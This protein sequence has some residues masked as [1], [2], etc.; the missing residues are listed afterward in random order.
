MRVRDRHSAFEILIE[1]ALEKPVGQRPRQSRVPSHEFIES[2]HRYALGCSQ[3]RR[4]YQYDHYRMRDAVADQLD[5]HSVAERAEVK[6]LLR[7]GFQYR[8]RLGEIGVRG[9]D[10]KRSLARRQLMHATEN[11]CLHHAR[12]GRCGNAQHRLDVLRT[13][14]AV[15]HDELA[16]QRGRS[17]LVE[18][19]A[20]DSRIGQA[21]HENVT[22][23][24][25]GTRIGCDLD[26]GS[27]RELAA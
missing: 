8:L 7:G 6:N 13:D 21:Q 17:H 25:D 23:F 22:S 10:Q 9:P 11:R 16:L 2:I 12:L 14:R 5:A 26:A 4:F 18:D 19:R 15:F 24:R 20:R 27:A 1:D 3:R